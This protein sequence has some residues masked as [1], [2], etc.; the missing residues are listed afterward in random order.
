MSAERTP[1]A[2]PS[3]LTRPLGWLTRLAVRFPVATIA[4]ALTGALLAMAYSGSRLGFRTSRQDRLFHAVLHEVDLSKIR[5]KGLHYLQVDELR[6]IDQFLDSAEPIVRGDWARLNL[7]NM[8]NGMSMRLE[9]GEGPQVAAAAEL[10]R[11]SES[12]LAA[13]G[14]RGR[15]QSPWPGV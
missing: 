8:A 6:S 10:G 15:Y 2:E 1:Q 5:N 11:L 7:G 12:L 3:L 13:M 14:Q 9:R 4:L